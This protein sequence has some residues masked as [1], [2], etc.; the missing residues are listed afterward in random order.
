[1]GSVEEIHGGE[2]FVRRVI[3]AFDVDGPHGSHCC[4][5]YQPTGV[6]VSEFI[7]RL[8][9]RAMPEDMLWTTVRFILIALD[10]LHQLNIVHTGNSLQ[11]PHRRVH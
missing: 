1:M 3:D 10:Y 2:R 5:L 8:K 7:D 11:K 6:H 4:L 9:G